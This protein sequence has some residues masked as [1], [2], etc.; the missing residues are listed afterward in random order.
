MAYT[1]P[2][3]TGAGQDLAPADVHH[4]LQTPTLVARRVKE[5]AQQKFISDFLLQGRYDVSGG[6]ISYLIDDG[7]YADREPEE[8]AAGGEYPLTP[9]TEGTPSSAPSEKDGQDSEVTDEAIKRLLMDPVERALRK[10]INSM[11]RR[12]DRKNLAVI[13]S[14]VTRTKAAGA[15]WTTADQ[16]IE[17]VLAADAV[18]DD[19]DLGIDGSVVVLNPAQYGKVAAKFVKADLA[20]NGISRSVESGVIG[21]FLGKTWLASKHLPFA[22]PMVLDPSLL[23]GIATEKLG[24]PGYTAVPG[25]LGIETKVWRPTDS[26]RDGYR[27]RVRRVGVAAVIEPR[28]AIRITGTGV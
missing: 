12:V 21:D 9:A 24:S 8:I 23:G 16:I 13:G 15:N 22:D 7:L 14:Q 18:L 17:D 27:L 1:Y 20:A 2:Y 25:T 19:D 5:L 3:V 28:A 4:F 6:A 11:V 10:L 26:D